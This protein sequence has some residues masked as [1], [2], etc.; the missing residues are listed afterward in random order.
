MTLPDTP[1]PI[2]EHIAHLRRTILW[3]VAVVVIAASLVLVYREPVIDFSLRPLGDTSEPLQFLAPLDPLFFILKV[4]FT[5]GLLIS[6]PIVLY[7][8]GRFLF[9]TA[10]PSRFVV[11]ISLGTIVVLCGL[12]AA[13]SYLVVVPIILNFMTSITVAGTVTNLT[14]HGY[15]NFLLSTT[16]LLSLVFQTPLIIALLSY[17]HIINPYTLRKKRAHAYVGIL[18][19]TAVISPTTDVI[20]LGLVALPTIV[21]FEVGVM[22]GSLLY[23]RP[24]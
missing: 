2:T 6:M 3:G 14:A 9:P 15:L 23:P 16:T 17:L 20:S 19:A 8:V 5:L 4:D 22:I 11:V 1:L 18:I 21:V 12:G 7:L 13:Y 10:S 24:K